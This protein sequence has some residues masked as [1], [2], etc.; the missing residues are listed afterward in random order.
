MVLEDSQTPMVARFKKSSLRNLTQSIWQV[1]LS[2]QE[3]LLTRFCGTTS[4][5]YVHLLALFFYTIKGNI[6]CMLQYVSGHGQQYKRV[7]YSCTFNLTS[8]LVVR[9]RTCTGNNLFLGSSGRFVI[10]YHVRS[11]ILQHYIL[12]YTRS[13]QMITQHNA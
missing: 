9:I 13:Y 10:Q 3:F 5:V 6:L 1:V 2:K 8:T 7:L 4:I 11:I 12:V